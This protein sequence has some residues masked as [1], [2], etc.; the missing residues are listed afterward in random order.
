MADVAAIV[1]RH[2]PDI[3]HLSEVENRRALDTFN[4]KFLPNSGYRSYF[5][6][7]MD[8]AT[9]QDVALLSRL[10]LEKISRD[11]RR[12]RSGNVRKGVSI[13][14]GLLEIVYLQTQG[15]SWSVTLCLIPR[16]GKIYCY[17]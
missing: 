13:H 6:P 1:R 9:G 16:K 10:R 12:G 3:L 7:G 4:E 2:D 14:Q 11:S 17:H 8:T 5:V 15:N